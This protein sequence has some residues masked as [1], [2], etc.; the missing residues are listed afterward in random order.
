M[1]AAIDSAR[2][3]SASVVVLDGDAGVGKTRLLGELT[4]AA[5]GRGLL[6]LVGHCVDLG[7]APPPYLPFSEAFARLAAEQPDLI[8]EL[9]AAHP[10]IARL[11]PH[12]ESHGEDD[13][14]GRGELFAAVLAALADLAA[15]QPLVLVV[16]DMH[17][18]DQAS[19]DLLGY[20][21]T[22]VRGERLAL[23]VS[24][25]SD[26]LHRRHPLRPTLAEWAR[27][28]SVQRVHLDPLPPE[29]VRTLV[30]AAH[31]RPL[32]EAEVASIVSRAD[33]NPFFAEELTAAADECLD[34]QQ[35]PW[36]LA[37]LLLVRLD[38]LSD[39]A[40]RIVRVAAVAGRRVSH[41]IL[42]HV[43]DVPDE[44]LDAALHE[45]IDAHILQLTSSGRGYTFRHA[46]LAEAVYDDL[47]PGELV[48]LHAAYAAVVAVRD[49]RSA[50]ELARHARAS[51]DYA[52]AYGASVRAG[53]DAMAVAAP[54]EAMQHYETA[55]DLRQRIPDP[56]D[57]S[58]LVVSLADASAA[59]GRSHRGYRLA[60]A[61]LDALDDDAPDGTRGKLLY[62]LAVAG[63][64]G[65]H[66]EQAR[67]ATTEAL[68]LVP[69]EPTPLRA[70]LAALH[71][72]LALIF[73]IEA[74]SEKWAREALD[75][76][77]R[78]GRPLASSDAET[79]LA[80]LQLRRSLPDEVAERLMRVAEG[81]RAHGEA[82]AE[83]RSRFNLGS[84]YLEHGDLPAAEQAY[85]KA[86][87]RA[88]EMGRPW[89]LFG[90]E[91][92]ARA[93][94]LQY[95]QGDWSAA[96]RTLDLDAEQA[97]PHAQARLASVRT[98]I[99]VARGEPDALASVAGLR[100]W[101]QRESLIANATVLAMLESYGWHGGADEA[102]AL[103]D[104]AVGLLSGLWQE[105]WFLGRLR[106]C[107]LVV[108][109]CATEIGA[110]SESRR[111]TLVDLARRYTGDGRTTAEKGMPNGRELGVEALAWQAR[112]EAEWARLRWLADA[113]APGED[114][115]VAAWERAVAAFDYG[116][117]TEL[118]RCRA[119]LAAILRAGGRTVEAAE[120]AGL[121]R[122]AARGMGAEPLLAEIRAL[123]TTP[124]TPKQALGGLGSLTERERDVLAQLVD[125]RTN[126][127]IAAH[128]YISEKTVS[129]HV[130]NILAKLEVRSRAEAAA[131]ARRA[132]AVPTP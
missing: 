57:A 44:R 8:E 118:A 20:L 97:T 106:F 21:F 28:P 3:A 109:A 83:I 129:V 27:L 54:Q 39:D 31:E 67:A 47:L 19:R 15:R 115:H 13:R 100:D 119:R 46:L 88:V 78:L 111:T 92:R 117:E 51:H 103:V 76:A 61:A 126:R 108:I 110:A 62:A 50:A 98:V 105:E 101:W 58:D 49:D 48:R 131:V 64:E 26:D 73:G 37:D 41:E 120:V 23:V 4:A 113:D 112:L 124:V 9:L 16:E 125:A 70:R 69:A 122:N 128:L 85:R 52:T 11:L 6:V 22:R 130:S 12:R 29:D 72:R 99:R 104:G 89:M 87:Q 63:I 34:A 14:I 90:V 45:A 114:E 59:A 74:E 68:R 2:E 18:A 84:L 25:R 81:A 38:R 10:Q 40:R 53:D 35:L 36:Q 56:P 79:T 65:E 102:A 75:I 33:G 86:W 42:A 123:G 93:A 32:A 94:N 107:T 60:R 71:A 43:V 95:E 96:L 82:A 66:D 116:N 121:A 127:Q 30:R 55:L 1:L 24:Y 5:T 77:E 91:S 132:D 80:L 17:W 7:D